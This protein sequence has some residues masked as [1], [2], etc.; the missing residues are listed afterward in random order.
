MFSGLRYGCYTFKT[1]PI[2]SPLMVEI[3]QKFPLNGKSGYYGRSAIT[4]QNTR[5]GRRIHVLLRGNHFHGESPPGLPFLRPKTPFEVPLS[6]TRK[7]LIPLFSAF[8]G[9]GR[10]RQLPA[11]FLLLFFATE[12]FNKEALL[13]LRNRYA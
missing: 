2:S 11:H 13:W 3:P 10:Y 9:F 7:F 8:S 6:T 1:F 5:Y 4:C 12:T